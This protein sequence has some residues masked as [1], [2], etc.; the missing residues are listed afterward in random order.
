MTCKRT[1]VFLTVIL[2]KVWDCWFCPTAFFTKVWDCLNC[3]TNLEFR[4]RVDMLGQHVSL[5]NI[6][7][8]IWVIWLNAWN[9]Q[10]SEFEFEY[11]TCCTSETHT[12][13]SH[14]TDKRDKIIECRK[15]RN[16]QGLINAGWLRYDSLLR[17]LSAFPT[18]QGT[19]FSIFLWKKYAVDQISMGSRGLQHIPMSVDRPY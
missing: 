3:P 1:T 4:S 13:L 16:I 2:S 5:D 19:T 10:Y 14:L 15:H 12:K 11:S 9:N 17:L 8:D 7:N 18:Q 6:T